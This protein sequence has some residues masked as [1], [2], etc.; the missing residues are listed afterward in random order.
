M[1]K[2]TLGISALALA[3]TG[4]AFAAGHEGHP[5]PDTNGDG[6]VTKAEA[7]AGAAA[8]F[9]KMDANND[10]KLDET[11]RAARM[12]ERK[13]QMFAMLDKDNDGSISRDEFMSHEHHGKHGMRGG[14]GDGHHRMGYHGGKGMMARADANNDGAV[15]Q[16]EFTAGA[17]TMFEKAD[18]NNDGKVTKEERDAMHKEMRGKWRD[19]M[20]NRADS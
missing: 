18:A 13:T 14:H 16:A 9:A 12:Q 15:S 20:G 8:M 2:I 6:V 7:Q 1:N 5:T 10:G 11:D 4:A 17:M 19:K 3:A